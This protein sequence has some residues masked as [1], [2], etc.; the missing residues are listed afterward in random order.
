MLGLSHNLARE[1]GASNIRVNTVL[2]GLMDN[3]RGRSLVSSY[4]QENDL[5][6]N[7]AET[8][9]LKYISLKSWIKPSEIAET[10]FFIASDQARHITGQEIAVDGNCEWEQ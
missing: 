2:P 4:A 6:I 9:F 7:E 3:P 8:E 10:T 5:S 1:L